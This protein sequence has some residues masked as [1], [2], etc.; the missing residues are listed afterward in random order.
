MIYNAVSAHTSGVLSMQ[1]FRK[2]I[3]IKQK[4]NRNL[5]EEMM[6]D[7]GWLRF[8]DPLPTL[9]QVE[10]LLIRE[11]LKQAKGNQT[12]AAGLLGITRQTLINK[13]KKQSGSE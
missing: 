8:P 7:E 9:K 2:V 10:S 11:A 13:L 6:P 4:T 3:D 12:I 5:S 1:S